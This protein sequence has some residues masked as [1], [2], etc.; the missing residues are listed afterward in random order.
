MREKVRQAGAGARSAGD[1]TDWVSAVPFLLSHLAPLGAFF[2]TVTWTDWTLFATLYVVRM[3]FVTAGYHRY[4]SHRSFKLG[5]VPQLILAVG[6]TTSAQKG[7]LWWAGH[8]RIH[9]R[10][11]DVDGDVHSPRDGF[12]WSHV[13][14][15]LSTRTKRTE[16]DAVKDF[17]A[18]PELR[19]LDRFHLVPPVALA[20]VCWL[21]GGPGGLLVGFFASTVVLWHA[22]FTVNSLAHLVGRRRFATPDTSRNSWLIA[23]ATGGE[24]WHNNHHYLP[25]SVR[26]GLTW[27]EVDTTWYVLRALA[28][29]HVVRDLRRPPER[30]LH[31][32]RLRDGAFDFGMFRSYWERAARVA[33]ARLADVTG[34]PV[35]AGPEGA[36]WSVPVPARDG[37]DVTVD[38]V[39][40]AGPPL[41]WLIARAL[42]SADQL[43]RVTRRYPMG[44]VPGSAPPE[45]Q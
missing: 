17:A 45:P 28:A 19:L 29:L 34:R 16:L 37:A 41:A 25:S 14:W 1:R 42:E 38:A 36:G 23:L 32:A 35:A 8:H 44:A 7:P 30:L 4:F 20:L 9:H 27:W 40:S 24:G 2:V 39:G 6:A 18:V 5:R 13:G 33:G 11:T 12:W 43:A 15:I 21:V 3:F 22:T 26:Q 10:F 31:Q